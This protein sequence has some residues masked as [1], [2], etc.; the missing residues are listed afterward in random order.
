[1]R[2]H[3]DSATLLVRATDQAWTSSS[4]CRCNR[5]ECDGSRCHAVTDS[6]GSP[7]MKTDGA[8]I[9]LQFE[10]DKCGHVR[11]L[12]SSGSRELTDVEKEKVANGEMKAST[13]GGR[14]RQV[15][16]DIFTAS[17]W[18]I[19]GTNALRSFL[20]GV[21]CPHGRD[22]QPYAAATKLVRCV[23]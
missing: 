14:T 4:L 12:W 5:P 23:G 3:I 8:A 2:T 6:T 22:N 7:L 1:M 15:N 16:H 10:C 9:M 17:N 20:E 13:Q 21:G 19:M 18:V 11:D